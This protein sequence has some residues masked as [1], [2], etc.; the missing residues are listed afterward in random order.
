MD[1][2]SSSLFKDQQNSYQVVDEHGFSLGLNDLHYRSPLD[3]TEIDDH[4]CTF[5]E[6][7]LTYG[8]DQF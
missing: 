4:F 8:L 6:D 7:D 3:M 2:D 1:H 5:G